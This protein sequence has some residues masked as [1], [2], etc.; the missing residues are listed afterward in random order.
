MNRVAGIDE[1]HVRMLAPDA[2]DER[3]DFCQPAVVRL[4]G[5]VIDRIDVAVE[6]RGAEDCYLN[7][8]GYEAAGDENECQHH[9]QGHE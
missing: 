7:S 8:F 4:V 5:I 1:Q 2:L 6:I 9:D 3:C